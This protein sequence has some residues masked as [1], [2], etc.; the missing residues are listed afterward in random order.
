MAELRIDEVCSSVV[1]CEHKTVPED[2]H[3]SA[4]AVGTPAM[5]DGQIDFSRAKRISDDTYDLWTRRAI[6]VEG[7]LILAREAPVGPVVRVPASPRVALG[8]RTVLLRPR[9]DVIDSR[10]L[11]F[12]LMSSDM[13]H[14]MHS[15]S[16]GSTVRHLNV[17]DVRALPLPALPPLVEQRAI[18]GVLGAL[19]DKIQSNHLTCRLLDQI[20]EFEYLDSLSDE[21]EEFLRVA[22]PILGGTP[23]RSNGTFWEPEVQWAAAKDVTHA[24]YGILVETSEGISHSGV[25]SSA[26][27]VLPSGTTV[28]TARG[29]VGALART[30]SPMAFS[31]SSYGLIPASSKVDPLEVYWAARQSVLELKRSSH[32]TVFDTITKQTFESLK[33]RRPSIHSREQVISQLRH[34][35]KSLQSKILE[36]RT[37]N[38]L[39]NELLPELLSGRLRVR[40]AESMMENV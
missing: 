18:V 29:T 7:D 14:R 20:M 8:Q 31:Q 12:L 19:D 37:L 39:R 33:V 25:M 40:D 21:E 27:K 28:I 2:M 13:Q 4:W 32:G 5:N 6:P 36:N 34:Y 23:S 38:Q 9:P 15:K 35:D 11:H 30:V 1:D 24:Q 10:Y 17:E 22:I 26:A 16:E 3:G